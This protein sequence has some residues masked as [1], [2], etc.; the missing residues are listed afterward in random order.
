MDAERR[1]GGRLFLVLAVFLIA[2]NLRPGATSIGPVIQEMAAELGMSA[3]AVGVVGALPGLTFAVVGAF[4]V[5]LAQRFGVVGAL[6]LALGGV[7]VG[8]VGRSVAD[9]VPLFLAL[10]V[11]A[12]AGMAVGNVLV[13]P[14]IRLRFPFHVPQVT[15]VYTV[16]LAV[17]S[18]LPA[19]LA[20]PIAAWVGWRASLGLWG[21]TALVALAAWVVLARGGAGE[22]LHPQGGRRRVR[23]G[24]LLRSP[25]AVALGVFFGM[26]SAQAYV[27]F[28]WAAQ[29]YRDGGVGATTAGALVSVIAAFGI[30]GGLLMPSA[31]ARNRHLPALVITLAVLLAAGYVG[32]W[33]A[34]AWLPWLWAVCLGLSGM[35]FPLAIALITARSRQPEVTAAL[36]AF[37]QSVGYLFAALGP[38]A[39]G[40]LFEAAGSWNVPLGL[41]AGSSI[42][43]AASGL[44]SVRSGYVDDEL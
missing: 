44:Y 4:G 3:T 18:M 6:V 35:C 12:F 16:G 14:F 8:L 43:L 13:P 29:I 37:V 33:L 5:G 30:P 41:L 11:L 1:H 40:A 31:V 42:V 20:A 27:Q 34:S 26:Q 9:S 23:L 24:Q 19:L 22:R 38:F 28:A 10:T 17:G 21:L 15:T 32:L 36:S 25:R 7:V 39:I 2:V